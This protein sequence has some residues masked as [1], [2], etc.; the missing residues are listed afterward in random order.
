MQGGGNR[1]Q[2]Q[3]QQEPGKKKQGKKNQGQ[4][5]PY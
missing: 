4:D 3:G 2:P 1:P 5:R